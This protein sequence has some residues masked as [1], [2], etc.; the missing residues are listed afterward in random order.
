MWRLYGWFCALM[1]CGSCVGVVT[2]VAWMMTLVHAYYG[3]DRMSNQNV[4]EGCSYFALAFSWQAIFLLSYAIEFLCLTTAKLMVLDHMS[5]FAA[6]PGDSARQRWTAGGRIVMAAVVLGNAVGLAASAASA[7][8]SRKASENF[9]T[10]S[11]SFDSK[12][13]NT[14]ALE[15]LESALEQTR[16]VAST[17]SVQRFSQVTVLLLIIAAFAVVGAVSARRVSSALALLRTAGPEMAAGMMLHRTTVGAAQALGR[18][19]RK[20][21]VGTSGFV[22]ASFLLRSVAS[23]ILAVAL[24]FE[25]ISKCPGSHPC[26]AS[27]HNVFALITIW[28]NYSPEFLPTV[29]L[30]SSPLALLVALWGM[31]SK[32]TRQLVNSSKRQAVPLRALQQ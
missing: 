30:I 32:R 29:V 24:Q 18:Q 11:A 28:Y 19:F 16:L 8:H 7:S 31:T 20:E 4:A 3:T 9:S 22:F 1:M 26:D 15:Y 12:T 21:V 10:A 23:T 13:N 25:N 14:I 6:P 2:W 5:D 27:C 17:A